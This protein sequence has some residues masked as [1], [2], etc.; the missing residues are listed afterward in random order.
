[1]YYYS[2]HYRYDRLN[3]DAEPLVVSKVQDESDEVQRKQDGHAA[4]CSRRYEHVKEEI[5]AALLQKVVVFPASS[6]ALTLRLR[7]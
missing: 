4:E 1:M 3:K 7:V 5:V 6:S 2:C